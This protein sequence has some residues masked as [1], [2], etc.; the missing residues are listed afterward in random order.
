MTAFCPLPFKGR[1]GVG[2]GLIFYPS[3]TR[4]THPHPNPSGPAQRAGRSVGLR[5]S[6][7]QAHR[8][9]PLEGE[10]FKA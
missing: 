2:M 9:H 7:A 10:G 6:A 4:E 8:P 3:V 5:G 1:A